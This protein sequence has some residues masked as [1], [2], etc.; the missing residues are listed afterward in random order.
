MKDQIREA[1]NKPWR[2]SNEIRRLLAYPYIRCAFAY[3]GISWGKRWRIL[4]MPIVQRHRSSEII[5]GNE[6]SIR[7][8]PRTNPLVPHHPVV[9]ATRKP[10]AVI[11]VGDNCGFS[12]TTFVADERIELGNRVQIGSNASLVDTDFHPLTPEERARDF[13]AGAAA[14]IE[15]NDKV[16]IGMDSL[17]LKGVTIG[18]GSVVGAGSVVSQDVPP[19]TVVAGNPAEVVHEL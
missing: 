8:W 3:H 11:R 14:P 4:G 2:I 12:G 15:V 10:G 1:L 7:S 9:L 17:I 13:N 18:Q 19:R 16:F 6:L 5:L